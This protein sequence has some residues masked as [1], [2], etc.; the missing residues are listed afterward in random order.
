MRHLPLLKRS[1]LASYTLALLLRR[2]FTYWEASEEPVL[3][4]YDANLR[5]DWS[6]GTIVFLE[7]RMCA[8]C[9]R[10]KDSQQPKLVGCVSGDVP[11]E[12]TV[13]GPFQR[14]NILLVSSYKLHDLGGDQLTT[15]WFR[16]GSKLDSCVFRAI[17]LLLPDLKQ[18]VPGVDG[19]LVFRQVVAVALASCPQVEL[20]REKCLSF[21][22][23]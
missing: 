13:K 15:G 1:H 20:V 5:G 2:R 6:F 23:G 17:D 22:L 16:T 21:V 7:E 8:F 18:E 11:A 12:T 3:I 10:R 19:A 4:V 14:L 9:Q